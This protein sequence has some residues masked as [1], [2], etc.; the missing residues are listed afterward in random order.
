MLTVRAVVV[1][2]LLHAFSAAC[3]PTHERVDFQRGNRSFSNSSNSS[4]SSSLSVER[5]CHNPAELL[6][7][8]RRHVYT[9]H[10][11]SL[12][13]L[14]VT[15]V[16]SPPPPVSRCM[17]HGRVCHYGR[18]RCAYDTRRGWFCKCVDAREAARGHSH[19]MIE[20]TGAL[21]PDCI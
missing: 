7:C 10:A 8:L 16:A 19:R 3:L 15:I 6:D 11:C 14:S 2:C 18:G 17:E 20:E 21:M 12:V 4:H 1:G 9:P 13:N 5:P